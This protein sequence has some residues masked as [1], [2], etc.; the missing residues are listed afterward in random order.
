MAP[1]GGW[2]SDVRPSA[3]STDDQVKLLG[4]RDVKNVNRLRPD[5][6]LTF[7]EYGVTVVFGFNGSGKSGYA[8]LI[9][10][11]VRTRHREEILPDVFGGQQKGREGHL[12]YAVGCEMA[13]LTWLACRR[14]AWPGGVL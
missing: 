14:S 7:G 11:L 9:K 6:Q 12:D 5:E 1:T 3:E 8:R 10:Q 4:V 13:R 2:V